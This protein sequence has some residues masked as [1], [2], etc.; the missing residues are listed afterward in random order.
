MASKAGRKFVIGYSWI[1]GIPF[2]ESA[3][4]AVSQS[5]KIFQKALALSK[6]ARNGRYNTSG[7]RSSIVD[8]KSNRDVIYRSNVSVW[9]T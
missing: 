2:S 4:S 3:S 8:V 7:T 6:A 1:L 5:G 9:L